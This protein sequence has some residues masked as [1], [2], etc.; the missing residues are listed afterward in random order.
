MRGIEILILRPRTPLPEPA[1]FQDER[2]CSPAQSDDLRPLDTALS[3]QIAHAHA[4]L[5]RAEQRL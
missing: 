4:A 5:A 3:A 2:S 1:E